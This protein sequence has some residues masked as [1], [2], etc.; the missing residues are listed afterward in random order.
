MFKG[1][2]GIG[3][4]NVSTASSLNTPGLLDHQYCF[5]SNRADLVLGSAGSVARL[6]LIEHRQ[7]VDRRDSYVQHTQIDANFPMMMDEIIDNAIT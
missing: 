4:I 5:V 7:A 2:I 3:T 6:L 1:A